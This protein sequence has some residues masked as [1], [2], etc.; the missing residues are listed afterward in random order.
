MA[1]FQ[2]D[3]ERK[4]GGVMDAIRCDEVDYLIWKWHPK[5]SSPNDSQRANAI[6][7]GSSLRVRDGSVAV[8]V[9]SDIEG[10]NQDFI[11]GPYDGLVQTNNFP[12]LATLVGKFYDGATPFPAE[13]YFINLA[14]LIQIKFGVPYFDIFDPRFTDYGIPTAVRGSINFR[15]ADYREFIRLH[16]LDSFDMGIF[17]DQVKDTVVRI[18]KEVVT[19]APSNDGIPAVQIERHLSEINALV[20][21]KMVPALRDNYGVS[22][23]RID[24][25]DIEINKNSSEYKK[26]LSLTQN[27]A[28]VFTQAAANIVDT[29]GTHRIGAKRISQTVKAEGAPVESGFDLGDVGKGVTDAIGGAAEAIGGFFSG[30]GKGKEATPPPIPG[31]RYFVA[32]GDTQTGPFGMSELKDM[33][34]SE[35]ITK[36]TL[37]WKDGMEDWQK[38]SAVEDYSQFFD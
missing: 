36:E 30:I 37:V 20:E 12:V 8:F 4:D 32:D 27:K 25:S 33:I 29:V 6:R 17:K 1:L 34:E 21:A 15:I 18:I 16:R 2:K 19:N 5:G 23:T 24:I 11:E 38:A 22:V 35:K 13:V 28:N 31:V 3:S 7:W 26:L 14:D 10:A 9:Y